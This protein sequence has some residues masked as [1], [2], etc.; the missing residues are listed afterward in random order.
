[1]RKTK[2]IKTELHN[3]KQWLECDQRYIL[4]AG[5]EL[6]IKYT[7]D[8][9]EV[10]DTAFDDKHLKTVNWAFKFFDNF[11][12][13]L[14]SNMDVK[15]HLFNLAETKYKFLIQEHIKLHGNRFGLTEK[16]D[17]SY[18]LVISGASP[19]FEALLNT[20]GKDKENEWMFKYF[21]MLKI[22]FRSITKIFEEEMGK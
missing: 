12:E 9:F 10:Q 14:K 21:K 13:K 2:K 1:M 16:S 3:K 20:L 22:Q 17:L 8:Y 5:I 15:K 7:K 19:I 4:L 6:I 11:Y 18:Y